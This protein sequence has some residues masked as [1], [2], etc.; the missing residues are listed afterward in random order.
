MCIIH[1]DKIR[2]DFK[3][4]FVDLDNIHLPEWLDTPPVREIYNKGCESDLEDELNEMY[5]NLELEVLFKSNNR[6]NVQNRIDA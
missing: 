4:C 2:E 5:V 1:L 6:L 3:I